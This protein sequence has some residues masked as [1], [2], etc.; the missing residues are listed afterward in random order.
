MSSSSERQDPLFPHPFLIYTSPLDTH[1]FSP[2]LHR[3]CDA[4]GMLLRPGAPPSK[5]TQTLW[6][7][8]LRRSWRR[9][10]QLPGGRRTGELARGE[11]S[12]PPKNDA[13]QRSWLRGNPCSPRG[14][15]GRRMPRGT[16]S[17]SP[18]QPPQRLTRGRSEGRARRPARLTGRV[19]RDRCST[20]K[21]GLG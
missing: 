11:R 3:Y 18:Q 21:P 19:P 14:W 12:E 20:Q 6:D 4:R 7:P 8:A 16:I 2:V 13:R 9:R 5:C 1:P 17:H 10:G 15:K